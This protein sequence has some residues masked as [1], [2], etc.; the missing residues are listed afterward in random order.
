MIK[1]RLRGR[2]FV[3]KCE[4][5]K[6]MPKMLILFKLYDI[7]IK[8]I[9]IIPYLYYSVWLYYKKMIEK[10]INFVKEDV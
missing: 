9:C 8:Y 5:S 2:G 10:I 4:S 3:D 6:K 1:K 7:I